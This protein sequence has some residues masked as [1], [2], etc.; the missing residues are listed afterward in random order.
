[1]TESASNY[2]VRKSEASES[3]SATGEETKAG[4]KKSRIDFGDA[5][6]DIAAKDKAGISFTNPIKGIYKMIYVQLRCVKLKTETKTFYLNVNSVAKRLHL[7]KEDI[8]E[9]TKDGT[10][11]TL[12]QEKSAHMAQILSE[13]HNIFKS[14]EDNNQENQFQ[15]V[16][17]LSAETLMKVVSAAVPQLFHKTESK[18]TEH[19]SSFEGT[20][21]VMAHKDEEG[22]FAVTINTAERVGK[23]TFGI[24]EK[25]KTLG[26]LSRATSPDLQALKTAQGETVEL[27][28]T[29]MRDLKLEVEVLRK[30]AILNGGKP[31]RGIQPPPFALI[32]ISIKITQSF[33]KEVVAFLGRLF[34]GDL[35]KGCKKPN[36][37]IEIA[38]K[39]GADI[40]AGMAFAHEQKIPHKDLKTENVL[41]KGDQAF[42][43]DWGGASI[44]DEKNGLYKENDE[45]KKHFHFGTH[46]PFITSIKHKEAA[47]SAWR[48]GDIKTSNQIVLEN[49]V[50]SAGA[51]L[52]EILSG[53]EEP[54]TY[55]DRLGYPEDPVGNFDDEYLLE[56]GVPEDV[57]QLIWEML[58]SEPGKTMSMQTAFERYEKAM[59]PEQAPAK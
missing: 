57:V 23:G 10:L 28:K 55:D 12:V 4:K 25:A 33:V 15:K 2:S 18:R 8:K 13:Y 30:F 47:E 5:R 50:F 32:E 27:T 46:S 24:V 22:K 1:M 6:I 29:A 44:L 35:E 40:L 39:H 11:E 34:D 3:Y 56:R 54:A 38:L 59:N 53:G 51:V 7:T 49:D 58:L 36:Y 14:Y 17:S 20:G 37:K 19:V 31:R 52:Y 16:T 21:F 45:G 48:E 42:V 9:A 41:F 26:S 43:S